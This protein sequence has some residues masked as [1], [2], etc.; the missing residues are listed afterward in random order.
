[1]RK[2]AIAAL[3]VLALGI[4]A[5]PALASH[6]EA[7]LAG[8]NFEIDVDA[9]LK[10]DDPAPPSLDWVN[11]SEIRATDKATGTT[12]DSYKGGVKEDTQCPG[13]TTGSIPNNK[14]DLLTFSVYE[15]EGTGG[16]PGFLN[17][18]WSRVTDP[19]GTTLMD[20]EFNQ[21]KTACAVGPNI[22]RTA[23]DL[24]IEYAIDQGGSRA[25]ISG[26]FW[27][28]TQWGPSQ[29]LD[30]PSA[31]CPVNGLP[32]PC[33]AGTIN[34]S[35]IPFGDSDGIIT[36]GS[37]APR[38]F[39][40]A[41]LDLRLLFNEDQCT[42]F[43]SA[44]LKSRSSD[45]FTSQ[46]KDFIRPASIDISNCGSVHVIKNDDA[47]PGNPLDG[48]E[49]DLVLDEA[50]IGGTPGVEDDTVVGSCTTVGGVCDFDDVL[51][52]EYWVIET[53]APTGYDLPTTPYQHVTVVTDEQVT[54]TFVDPAQLGA[55]QITKTAKNVEADG[56][57][58][59]LDGVTFTIEGGNLPDGGTDVVTANGGIACLDGLSFAT[60]YVVTETVPA[61]YVAD[62]TGVSDA[63]TVDNK[64]ACDDDP[65]VGETV[66]FNNLP[67]TD[68]Q[69]SVDSHV[70]GGTASTIEC[71]DADGN[72]VGSGSTTTGG[73][74]AAGEVAADDLAPGTYTCTVVIDP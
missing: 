56:G 26:R 46:L 39:G 41:Q 34:S 70:D 10:V 33:A 63:I 31:T 59:N 20:F 44:M 42:S 55:I 18:A 11:V 14:S 74:T 2:V 38:T 1:M 49:F 37:L 12:D 29:D 62:G 8:S 67:L 13:E 30:V 28:G 43:G 35:S 45:A 73:D 17:L 47:T 24:L 21:S 64:A 72:V 53:K 50:P 36:S 5:V 16:H 57:S 27:T 25:D 40:E 58:I 51:Q 22:V 61:D 48:A 3:A 32:A 15:E 23:G 65:Y 9:N 68:V 71:K 4:V 52:G 6:P 69:V 54:V 66:A 60:D 7:S 19:S